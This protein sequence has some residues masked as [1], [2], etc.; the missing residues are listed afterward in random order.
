[1]GNVYLVYDRHLAT[2]V[3]LK[4]LNLLSGMDLYRFK[5]EFRS[6]AHLRHINLVT[7]FEL[8]SEGALWFF[9]MEYLTGIP[10]DRYLLPQPAIAPSR[11]RFLKTVQQVC[12]GVHVLHEAGCIHRDLKPSNVLVTSEGRAVILDFGLAKKANSD[13]LS[14]DGISGTP[15]YMAPEQIM[16]KPCQPAADWYAVGT[17][18]YEV[19]TGHCPFTGGSFEVLLKKQSEDPPSPTE[20]NPLADPWMSEFCMQLIHRDQTRRPSGEEILRQLGVMNTGR[21]ISQTN[22]YP[23]IG[24]PTP[25]ILGR[26]PELQM[27]ERSF[28]EVCNGRHAVSMIQ[29]TSGIGKTSL[30]ETFLEHRLANTSATVI[31]WVLRGR[32]HEREA[33]PFKAFDSVVDSLTDH[34]IKVSEEDQTYVLPDGIQY[35]SEIF[36]VLRRL[37]LTTHERYAVPPLREATELR[38]Q[39]FAAFC[40]LLARV[41]RIRP[42]VVFIDDLQWADLDSF[43][44]LRAIMRQPGAPVLFLILNSRPL[45]DG[46]LGMAKPLLHNLETYPGVEVIRL[47][48]LS[49][50]ATRELTENRIDTALVPR[51]TRQKIVDT[52][53]EE[54]GGNPFFVVELVQH[55]LEMVLPDGG[56]AVPTHEKAFHLD[57]MILKRVQSLP[58]VSQRLMEIIATAGDPLPQQ[59]LAGAIGVA[60]GSET[61]ERGIS[62]L[63]EERL[64]SRG[65]RQGE[66]TVMM[67]HDRIRE[68]VVR[69]LDEATVRKLHRQLAEAVERWDHGRSDRLARYWLSAED[70]ERA[71]KYATD[72]AVEA[73]VKLAFD[74]AAEF[75]E[76][77]VALETDDHEKIELLRALGDCRAS[78]GN[79]GLAAEAYQ[80]AASMG[81]TIQAVRLHHLAAEQLLRGGQIAE[82]LK[83]LKDVLKQA[84]IH[85]AP[86]PRRAFLSVAWRLLWLRVR[87]TNFTERPESSISVKNQRLLDILW[88]V[89]IGLGV[90]D[91]LHADDFLLRFLLLA[92]KTGDIHRVAQGLS[93]LAGQIAAIGSS[94]FGFSMSL[95]A[96]AD[97]LARRSSDPQTIGLVQMCKGVVHYFAGEWETA[98]NKLT[99]VEQ[100]FLSSCHGV[101]WELATTRIF[102]CYAL[103]MGGRL[104]ELCERFDRYI[105]DADRA[106]D[107]Y[108]SA[109]LR[110][111][112][113]IVWLIR[114]DLDRARK[115][116]EGIL[117]AW[118]GDRYQLQ[119]FTHLFARCEQ[120]LYAGRPNDA[121]Q[122]ILAEDS[123]IRRSAMLKISAIHLEHGWLYARIAL[124]MAEAAPM[125]QRLHFLRIAQKRVRFLRKADHQ[126]GVAM[127]A[128]IAAGV[129]WL[130]PG[131]N[132]QVGIDMLDRAVATAE[133]SGANLL[134]ESG[135]HWLGELVGGAR[136][137]ALRAKSNKW[138]VEQGVQNPTR[139]AYLIVPGFQI[140]RSD[141]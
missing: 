44:L 69:S 32:C 17:M 140:P 31:P 101:S 10:F 11:E 134:A 128:A 118:P 48:P 15:A 29:G 90:V 86:D 80:R 35:L 122:A 16:E 64:I 30:V 117:D 55:V 71:K 37:K 53:V 95:L 92:L 19:L 84:G 73:R 110:T 39:A 34:L 8:V 107:H 51:T 52:I 18:I 116:I 115:G 60:F 27:L 1:M 129:C 25:P 58:E 138:M 109:N 62:V 56:L 59:T 133:A 14:G 113:S 94:H 103:R 42:F 141:V 46:N 83:V 5:R 112:H 68:T 22:R 82:G 127:E 28:Q 96:K 81:S 61:W 77:A 125:S 100:Y 43:A 47:G 111:Y 20:L 132:K 70:H 93:V 38:N 137:E 131:Q 120:A 88:S 9:T 2:K 75:Y 130:T 24:T 41:A 78:N 105:V 89:N 102:A 50:D 3:A 106:G 33:L 72:A 54:A 7:L 63:V 13:S 4:T 108:L 124:A 12:T 99:Y 123:S 6:M 23:V 65:G 139:L 74:R 121:Y 26:E 67:Y 66:D 87:G 104:R 135:R 45:S 49:D 85:L 98:R 79:S 126:T 21:T 136:G 119:H 40:E 36:P 57:T 97:V 91:I 76:T 114:D